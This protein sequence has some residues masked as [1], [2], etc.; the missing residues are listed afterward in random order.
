MHERGN[1]HGLAGT[2]QP[3]HPEPDGRVYEI[4][5]E[6]AGAAKCVGRGLG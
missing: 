6:I 1:E 3:R 5:G 2:S 4:G